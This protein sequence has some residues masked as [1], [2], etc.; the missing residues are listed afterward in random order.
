VPY[1]CQSDGGGCQLCRVDFS[2]WSDFGLQNLPFR[3]LNS[4]SGLFNLQPLLSTS[5]NQALGLDNNSAQQNSPLFRQPL[6]VINFTRL[7]L[8]VCD[9]ESEAYKDQSR[10]LLQAWQHQL[11]STHHFSILDHYLSEYYRAL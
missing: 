10:N 9:D 11:D 1:L 6:K 7:N 2:C 3:Q 5:I 8:F 4:L